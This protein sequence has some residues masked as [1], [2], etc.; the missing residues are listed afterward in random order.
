MQVL[1]DDKPCAVDATTVGEAI[2]AASALARQDGRL[3]VEVFVDGDHW[4]ET[5]LS[6]GPQMTASAQIIRLISAVPGKLVGQTFADAA[7]ALTDIEQLQREAAELLQ[8]D[9]PTVSLDKLGEAL[10]TWLAVQEA[11]IKGARLVALDLDEVNA[12]GVGVS[13]SIKRLNQRLDGV[14]KALTENDH[15]SLADTLLYEFPEVIKEWRGMLA[16]LQRRATAS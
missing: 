3:I 15:V 1:L 4:G 12:N 10:G 6:S 14:R 11:I 9:K 2:E 7:E 13:E 8:S 16:E 5:E